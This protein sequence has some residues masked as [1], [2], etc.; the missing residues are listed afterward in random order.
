MPPSV[1]RRT[2]SHSSQL[3][4]RT[5]FDRQIGT[6][7]PTTLRSLLAVRAFGLRAVGDLDAD[8]LDRAI[9]WVH[10]SDLPDPTPWLEPGQLLLTDGGQFTGPGSTSPEAY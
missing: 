7:I 1:L 10:N 6:T 3:S 9:S 2:S 4:Y 5:L 8:H